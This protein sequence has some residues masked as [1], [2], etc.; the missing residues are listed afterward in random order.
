MHGSMRGRARD[1][2]IVQLAGIIASARVAGTDPWE[3]P[4]RYDD[5]SADLTAAEGFI[6]DWAAFVAKT[7]GGSP[8]RDQLWITAEKETRELVDRNW[9]AITAIATAL[10]ERKNLSYDE[11]TRLLKDRNCEPR[12]GTRT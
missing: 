11:V 4:P 6:G 7:Y 1:L 8:P 3:T 12:A 10:M 9:Q 2:A 5:D